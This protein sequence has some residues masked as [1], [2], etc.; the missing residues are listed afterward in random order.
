M[1]FDSV[2]AAAEEVVGV[3]VASEL[4]GQLAAVVQAWGSAPE[5]QPVVS[6]VVEFVAVEATAAGAFAVGL[7]VVAVE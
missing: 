5:W 1:E 7:L 6:V 2:V 4:E 3:A